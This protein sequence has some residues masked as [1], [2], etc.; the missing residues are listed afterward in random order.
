MAEE[1][2][3]NCPFCGGEI[4]KEAIKCRYCGKWLNEPKVEQTTIEEKPKTKKCPACGEEILAEARKCKHCGE[5]LDNSVNMSVNNNMGY[6]SYNNYYNKPL[7]PLP[8]ELQKFN[9]GAF[10]FSWIW[11]LY[12]NCNTAVC[13]GIGACLASAI[14]PFIGYFITLGVC[15]WLGVKGN[16]LAWNSKDWKGIEDFNSVQI[17]WA[18]GVIAQVVLGVMCAISWAF[19]IMWAATFNWGYL[20]GR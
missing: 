11:G 18:K 14:I 16:E 8:Y 4:K 9:W 1:D 7:K 6:N 20:Y 19:Y 2:M 5:M 3:K 13:A 10:G 15:I 17:A 12:N